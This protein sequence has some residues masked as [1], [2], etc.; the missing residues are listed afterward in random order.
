MSD[1]KKIIFNEEPDPSHGVRSKEVRY[2]V[3]RRIASGGMATVFEAVR[4][5]IGLPVAIKCLDKC[6]ANNESWRRRFTREASLL[7]KLEHP[8]LVKVIDYC[9]DSQDQSFLVMELVRGESLSAR[10]KSRP[11]GCLTMAELLNL[12]PQLVSAILAAHRHGIVHR[13][14][15][16]ENLMLVSGRG[17][18]DQDFIK[19][20]D[21]GIACALDDAAASSS[22]DSGILGTPAY[23]APEQFLADPI[24]TYTDVYSLGV[25]LFQAATGHLPFVGSVSEL[26]RQHSRH[27]PP[28]LTDLQPGAPPELCQLLYEMMAKGPKSR[29]TME[30]VGR[31]FQALCSQSSSDRGLPR[32]ERKLN[33]PR[34]PSRSLSALLAAISIVSALALYFRSQPSAPPPEHPGMVLLSG[35]VTLYGS[36]PQEAKAALQICEQHGAKCDPE[37]FNR[38]TP[39]QQIEL[40]PFYVDIRPVTNRELTDYLNSLGSK[41]QL[42]RDSDTGRIRFVST[43]DSL[44]VDMH[45]KEGG[46][47]YDPDTGFSVKPER[48][49]LPARQ[50]TWNGALRYC[51][52][53]G[54]RMLTE[55]EWEYMA[56]LD[57]ANKR[58]PELVL[59]TKLGEW[60]QD[61]HSLHHPSCGS[62]CK[63]P[64]FGSIGKDVLNYRVVRGCA[65]GEDPVFCR[66]T[67]RGFK[68]ANEAGVNITFRCAASV[69]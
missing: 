11:D 39:Q 34:I 21:F 40:S 68:P 60:T 1:T 55:A 7:S 6:L 3:L 23:M 4:E 37:T 67:A 14:L 27:T 41:L 38:E 33:A 59:M 20:I 63:D 64:V 51:L 57:Q 48:A 26:Q 22:P 5:D 65:Q 13:D 25:V 44:I 52:F 61:M 56:R 42:A 9:C 46:V 45:D 17:L 24:G 31:V 19:V 69:N 12:A 36:T 8:H 53:R 10:L 62:D 30:E 47:I 29:P 16:P 32:G 35:G 28:R 66:P 58:P 18:F 2:R 15:K 43:E 49:D 54:K 50:V